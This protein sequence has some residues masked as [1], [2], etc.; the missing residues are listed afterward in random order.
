MHHHTRTSCLKFTAAQAHL[1]APFSK[2]S[3]H[4]D[5]CLIFL[6]F[7]LCA[8]Y[9]RVS[10]DY[11]GQHSTGGWK[12]FARL[13]LEEQEYCNP[14]RKF[15]G[16]PTTFTSTRCYIYWKSC[17]FVGRWKYFD[18]VSSSVPA[19]IFDCGS[20]FRRIPMGWVRARRGHRSSQFL[21]SA[22]LQVLS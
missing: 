16:G 20:N 12:L 4:S 1:F 8:R 13:D 14:C 22:L 10:I 21:Y 9:V 18:T 11:C 2:S 6:Y 19:G 15:T 3:L 7:I 5:V 17:F